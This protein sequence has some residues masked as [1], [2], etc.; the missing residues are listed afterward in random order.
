VHQQ[1]VSSLSRRGSPGGKERALIVARQAVK[2]RSLIEPPIW[3]RGILM[4]Q[5]G[6]AAA[7]RVKRRIADNELF[8]GGV[9]LK[10]GQN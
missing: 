5:S 6:G 7:L 9:R 2:G 8:N 3:W 10:Y 4:V 1:R